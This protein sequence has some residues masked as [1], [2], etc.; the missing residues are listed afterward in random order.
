MHMPPVDPPV[1]YSTLGE[2]RMD[3]HALFSVYNGGARTVENNKIL[4]HLFNARK[5]SLASRVASF[6][7]I[8]NSK[9]ARMIIQTN[10]TQAYLRMQG[11]PV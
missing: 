1:I 9:W 6:Y 11:T 7:S 8:L 5:A 3:L 4:T 2:F 10:V